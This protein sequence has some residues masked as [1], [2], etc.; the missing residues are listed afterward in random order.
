M[1]RD[2]LDLTEPDPAR[3]GLRWDPA[4]LGEILGEASAATTSPARAH[5]AC[6]DAIASYLAGRGA[7]AAPEHVRVVSTRHEAYRRLLGALC[8]PE[9]EILVAS[10][11]RPLHEEVAAA[12]SPSARSYRLAYDREW[13]LDRRSLASALTRRT[14]AIVVGNPSDPAGAVLGAGDLAF[15]EDLCRAHGIALVGEEGLADTALVPCASV[16]SAARCLALQISGLAGVCGLASLGAEWVA[17]AGPGDLVARALGRLDAQGGGP[18]AA[19]PPSVQL[20][21]PALLAR[22]QGFQGALRARLAG[23]RASLA[24]AALREAPWSLAWG[25]GGCWGVLQIGAAEPD[26]AVCRALLDDGVAVRPGSY[27]GFPD[28]GY[29]VVSLLPPPDLFAEALARLDRRLRAPLG[30]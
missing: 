23:N 8:E 29:L 2:L 25:R 20:A 18:D 19:V 6:R 24:A 21:V 9:D 27:Y 16:L 7:P 28:R 13:H 10:P 17:A 3:W 30:A 26:E 22:R 15:L 11:G 4:L 5:E 12:R 14:R 1:N